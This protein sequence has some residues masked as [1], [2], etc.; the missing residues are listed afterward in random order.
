MKAIKNIIMVTFAAT[1]VLWQTDSRPAQARSVSAA[2]AERAVAGWLAG[3]AT[4]LDAPL[5]R[6]TAGV[7]SIANGAG[8]IICYVV[9]TEPAGYVVADSNA[10]YHHM[11]MGWAGQYD[12]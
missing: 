8:H 9:H 4:P 7:E 10:L 5:G 3:N 12:L 1:S 11:N 6:Q 2:E